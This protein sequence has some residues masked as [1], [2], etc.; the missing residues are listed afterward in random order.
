MN[1]AY[2]TFRAGWS[3][4]RHAGRGAQ[5]RAPP[6]KRKKRMWNAILYTIAYAV[7]ALALLYGSGLYL[8]LMGF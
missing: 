7:L 6:G 1:E 5:P 3:A 4:W 8:V 2:S